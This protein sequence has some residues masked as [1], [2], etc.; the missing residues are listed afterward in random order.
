MRDTPHFSNRLG[1]FGKKKLVNVLVEAQF[2]IN[3]NT[4][5]LMIRSSSY[6]LTTQRNNH[7]YSLLS[8]RYY[9]VDS[10]LHMLG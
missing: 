1:H 5:E 10:L 8:I 9:H 7:V 4:G 3:E 6:R 2:G